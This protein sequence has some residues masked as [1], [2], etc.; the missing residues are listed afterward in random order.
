MKFRSV[1]FVATQALSSSCALQILADSDIGLRQETKGPAA[2]PVGPSDAEYNEIFRYLAE[3]EDNADAQI[4]TICTF[5]DREGVDVDKIVVITDD[6]NND[7]CTIVHALA[8]S[9]KVFKEDQGLARALAGTRDDIEL[10]WLQ[11]WRVITAAQGTTLAVL[12][13]LIKKYSVNLNTFIKRTSLDMT[14]SS[15]ECFGERVLEIIAQAMDL[16]LFCISGNCDFI[17]E[18]DEMDKNMA[19]V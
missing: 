3:T 1:V 11:P 13:V 10:D 14:V 17:A 9:M 7:T 6:A 8:R 19:E 12:D 2:V 4:A 5:L 15:H 16:S 18:K